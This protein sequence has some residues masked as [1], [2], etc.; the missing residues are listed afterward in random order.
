MVK[1]L[2]IDD[3]KESSVASLADGLTDSGLIQVERMPIRSHMSFVELY[4]EICQKI[5]EKG[6][7]GILLDM[8]LNGGGENQLQYSA[9][10]LAQQLRTLMSKGEMCEVALVL[11]STDEKMRLSYYPDK[12]S[13]D[14][15]DYR[16]T[17]EDIAKSPIIAQRM[18]A[19]GNAY[20]ILRDKRDSSIYDI[21][22]HEKSILLD[23]RVFGRFENQKI[24]AYD[25][26]CYLIKH[27]FRHPGIMINEEFLAARLGIDINNTSPDV[28][29]SLKKI[30]VEKFGY[31]G[32]LSEGWERYWTD[33]M[34]LYFKEKGVLLNALSAQ[35][36]VKALEQISGLQGL[37]AADPIKFCSNTYYDTVC[38]ALHKPMYSREGYEV[39][40]SVGL[41]PWQEKRFVSLYA[42]QS[43]KLGNVVLK[44]GEK[45][46]AQAYIAQL[47]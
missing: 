43:G 27:V 24:C 42:I 31:Q 16:F 4:S 36:R 17:K 37:V 20:A 10:P 5:N 30:C 14:L 22:R 8:C 1:Y 34:Y 46:R 41:E 11:C 23:E 18:A 19:I 12:A 39:Y 38:M 6:Y 13:H 33:R 2:Y 32:L 21:V 45:E 3:E 47:K 29:N 26:V 28:W 35:E 7:D 15:Y 25:V 44:A 9:S 40:C